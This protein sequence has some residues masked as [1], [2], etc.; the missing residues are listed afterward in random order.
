MLQQNIVIYQLIRVIIL[1]GLS[2]LFSFIMAPLVLKFLK[3]KQMIKHIRKDANAPIFTAMHQKKEGTPTTAGILIWGTVLLFALTFWILSCFSPLFAN[4]FNFVSRSETFLI[5]GIM[6]IAALVGLLDDLFGIYGIGPKGGGL[7]MKQRILIYILI[8]LIGATWFF[9]KLEWDVVLVPFMGLVHLGWLYPV[10]FI[11]VFTA[12]AFSMNETDGIDGL[13]AGVSMIGLIAYIFIVFIQGRYNVAV[14][15]AVTLG[16]LLA[17]LWH[18]INPAEFF[19]GDTGVMTLGVLF[20]IL[21]MYTNTPLFLPLLLLIPM[22]ESGSVIIQMIYKK[23]HHGKKL[24]LSTPFH[25]HF[26]ALGWPETKVTMRF[27]MIQGLG[28]MI[29]VLLYL[30]NIL[31]IK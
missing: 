25:H 11:F 9:W 31:I 7:S 3:K 21:A 6:S 16:A 19:M 5:L 23:T 26:E 2:A 13:S 24:F 10:F 4:F 1:G 12:C 17:Y 28:A 29:G 27:W 14:L 22:L 18:N 8:G 30:L 15:L 20:G